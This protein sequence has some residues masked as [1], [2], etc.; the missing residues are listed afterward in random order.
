MTVLGGILAATTLNAETIHLKNGEQI[1]AQIIARDGISVTIKKG[2]FP[3]KIYLS[4]IDR[5]EAPIDAYVPKAFSADPEVFKKISKSK[6]ALILR[7]LN[8]NGT[9]SVMEKN[10]A[11][12]IDDAPP[13]REPELRKMFDINDIL[14]NLI[15]VYAEYYDEKELNELIRFYE[16]PIGQKL[17]QTAP[18]ILER[19]TYT[20]IRYFQERIKP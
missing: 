17:L 10:I 6:A 7:L 8:A 19:S 14:E 1:E 9:R 5:I 20:S 2:T 13:E 16:S 15:P 4:D 3:E 18:T 12:V 11:K